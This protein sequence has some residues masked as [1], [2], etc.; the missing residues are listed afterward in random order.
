MNKVCTVYIVSTSNNTIC[1]LVD[2][3]AQVLA[4]A[5]AGTVGF[6]NSRKSTPYAAQAVGERIAEKAM[7][8]GYFQAR[9]VLKGIG[10]GK[11]AATRA[12]AKSK[13]NIVSLQEHTSI[14]HN[15]CRAPRRRRF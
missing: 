1:T 5:T 6:K 14:P 2:M 15:G 10:T 12:I 4:T 9:I 11:Q 7:E 3:R 13:L 8:K